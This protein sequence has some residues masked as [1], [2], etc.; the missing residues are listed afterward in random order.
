MADPTAPDDRTWFRSQ[1]DPV[2]DVEAIPDAWPEI[3][4]RVASSAG[5]VR[6]VLHHRGRRWMAA[7]AAIVILTGAALVLTIDRGEDGS[8]VT[9]GT[10]EATG[11]YIPQ[12]LPAGWT[13]DSVTVIDGSPCD[14]SS[15]RWKTMPEAADDDTRPAIELSYRACAS[16][17]ADPGIAGPRIGP[18]SAASFFAPAKDDPTDQ[19]LRWEDDGLWELTGEG[20]DGDRLVEAAQAIADD[21]TSSDPPL[22]GMGS[23]SAGSSQDAAPDGPPSVAVSLRTP[24][25]ALT[26]YLLVEPGHGPRLTPFTSDEDGSLAGQPLGLRRRGSIPLERSARGLAARSGYL[27][28]AWPGADV[29]V[30]ERLQF[31]SS[32]EEAPSPVEARAI[33]EAL[34][35]SLR[36][37]SAQAWRD[38]V[39]TAGRAPDERLLSAPTLAAL[40]EPIRETSGT[41]PRGSAT[42][43]TAPTNITTTT[44][45]PAATPGETPGSVVSGPGTFTPR[46]EI[47]DSFTPIESLDIRLELASD[48]IRAGSPVAGTLIVENPTDEP[49]ELNECSR[50]LSEWGLVPAS[51]PDRKL[52]DRSI[53]DCYGNEPNV[54][55]RETVRFPLDWIRPAGFL[56]QRAGKDGWSP[57]G[58]L[59]GGEYLAVIDIPG[60]TGDLRLSVPVTVP[61]PVCET[62]DADVAAYLRHSIE[63]AKDVAAARSGDVPE[64][65]RLASVDGKPVALEGNLGCNRINIDIDGGVVVNAV[66]Y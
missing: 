46:E 25:G 45:P 4:A 10:G 51:D 66:R 60:R 12:G 38:F 17:P 11:W 39:A 19:V 16:L 31:G 28:G 58:T 36:P 41:I 1:V 59:P 14:D 40:D 52:P 22:P 7:A 30:N 6:P 35:S 55:A 2:L 37:A 61:E 49:I 5:V 47:Y 34:A 3:E 63:G 56:A 44:T 50:L 13:L 29:L 23:T 62:T 9:T 8:S 20:F 24:S 21:P 64:V 54:G 48:T 42:S 65:L 15:Q 26:S 53:I 57:A 43:T 32:V 33:T 18:R 27:F